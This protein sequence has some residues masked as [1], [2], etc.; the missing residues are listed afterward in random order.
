MTGVAGRYLS[1]CPCE[2]LTL[3]EASD[4]AAARIC[5]CCCCHCTGLGG[6]GTRCCDMRCCVAAS[7]LLPAIA[8]CAGT[9]TKAKQKRVS[10]NPQ[11]PEHKDTSQASKAQNIRGPDSR[12]VKSKAV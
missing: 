11:D 7:G 3:P 10:D 9:E 2:A 5:S 6:C 4:S 1:P 12:T 8:C